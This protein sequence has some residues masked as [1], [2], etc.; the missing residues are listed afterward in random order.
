[1]NLILSWNHPMILS[2]FNEQRCSS[3]RYLD[4]VFVTRTEKSKWSRSVGLEYHTT[5]SNIW[6]CVRN[7]YLSI[8]AAVL[9]VSPNNW[10]RAFSPISTPPVTGPLCNPIL[11]VKSGYKEC[12]K[13]IA[14]KN[15]KLSKERKINSSH[16]GVSEL[17]TGTRT[18][19]DF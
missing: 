2:G 1:M 5:K 13:S 19:S 11:I 3:C 8:R 4:F 6:I 17:T 12:N 9:T 7:S 14:H 18:K 16:T 10:K 15:C